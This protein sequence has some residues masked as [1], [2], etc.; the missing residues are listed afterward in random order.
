MVKVASDEFN[1]KTLSTSETPFLSFLDPFS[2][3][4]KSKKNMARSVLEFSVLMH[5]LYY[6]IEVRMGESCIIA[7]NKIWP[8]LEFGE[9]GGQEIFKNLKTSV[10]VSYSIIFLSHS[11]GAI[12]FYDSI[13]EKCEFRGRSYFDSVLISSMLVV[14]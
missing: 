8:C 13:I 5:I 4:A 6:I 7:S 9:L 14:C 11:Q 10:Y 3:M 12:F 1:T 2:N